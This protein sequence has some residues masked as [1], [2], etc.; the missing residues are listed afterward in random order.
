MSCGLCRY[1]SSRLEEMRAEMDKMKSMN[2]LSATKNE[3]IIALQEKSRLDEIQLLKDANVLL[4]EK[5]ELLQ[6]KIKFL[7]EK[8]AFEKNK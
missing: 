4:R 8:F 2:K 3:Q 7:E 1:Y 6:E 5:N